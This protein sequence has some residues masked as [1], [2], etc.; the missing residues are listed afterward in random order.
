MLIKDRYNGVI[1]VASVDWNYKFSKVSNFGKR[2]DML[3]PGEGIISAN[4][5]AKLNATVV[6]KSGTGQ[7]AA[8]VA[9]IVAMFVGEEKLRNAGS[10]SIVRRRL[11]DNAQVGLIKGMPRLEKTEHPKGPKRAWNTSTILVNSGLENPRKDPLT[12]YFGAPITSSA[13]ERWKE[14]PSIVIFDDRP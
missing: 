5:K 11:F 6:E 10:V 4:S 7:A 13:V 8:H 2:V 12:A 14:V 3:A 1:C 9:G